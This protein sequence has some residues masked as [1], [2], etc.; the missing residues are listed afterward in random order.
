M[1]KPGDITLATKRHLS[2]FGPYSIISKHGSSASHIGTKSPKAEHLTINLKVALIIKTTLTDR[3]THIIPYH[4]I[5]SYL[6]FMVPHYQTKTMGALEK[7]MSS[8]L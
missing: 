2:N 7:Q 6:K 5:I 3:L 4:I 8:F 1:I